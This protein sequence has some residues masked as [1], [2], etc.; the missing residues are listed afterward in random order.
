MS[1]DKASI[2]L[3]LLRMAYNNFK[4]KIYYQE[5]KDILNVYVVMQ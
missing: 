1:M 3:R 2:A 5:Y 4:M